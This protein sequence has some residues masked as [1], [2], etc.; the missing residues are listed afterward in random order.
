[1]CFAALSGRTRSECCEAATSPRAEASEADKDSAS[2]PPPDAAA[3]PPASAAAPPFPSACAEK[4][5]QR[6][7]QSRT[8]L[9]LSPAAANPH[10]PPYSPLDLLL[11]RP[12]VQD[13]FVV[14]LLQLSGRHVQLLVHFGVLVI[15]LPEEVHLLRQVLEEKQEVARQERK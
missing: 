11:G 10:P 14:A 7:L 6:T 8:L 5:Q 12:V 1:M 13:Q 2:A 15:D 4:N 9:F 3:P